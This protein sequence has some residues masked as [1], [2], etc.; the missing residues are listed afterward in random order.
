VACVSQWIE[1]YGFKG[2]PVYTHNNLADLWTVVNF[3]MESTGRCISL[4][5][6]QPVY[7]RQHEFAR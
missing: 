6:V 4:V 1:E 7:A 5:A 3:I 2:L